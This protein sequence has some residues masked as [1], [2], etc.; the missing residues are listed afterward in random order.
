MPARGSIETAR[1]ARIG[2]PHALDMRSPGKGGVDGSNIP[3]APIQ[4]DVARCLS[5]QGR[6]GRGGGAFDV[7]SRF[8]ASELSPHRFRGVLRLQQGFRHDNGEWLA[9]IAHAVSRQY[10]HRCGNHRPSITAGGA[11]NRRNS[12]DPGALQ[13][14]A[15]KDA[16]HAGHG[17]R[18][19]CVHALD[20]R[21][22]DLRPHENRIRLSRLMEVVGEMARAGNEWHVLTA[23]RAVIAAEACRRGVHE[24][25]FTQESCRVAE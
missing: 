6:S 5:V 23:Q 8:Q 17:P 15:G 4:R 1:E 14:G 3:V 13:I 18:A 25:P 19:L 9:D 11:G 7:G 22:R 10:R 12:A 21:V 20:D 24:S 2:K 16:E